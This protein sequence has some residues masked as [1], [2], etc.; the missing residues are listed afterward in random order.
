MH[1]K[2]Y[3]E[4]AAL[5]IQAGKAIM[6]VYND[7]ALFA[8]VETKEDKSPLTWADERS[9]SIIAE[10][11]KHIT[12]DIHLISEEIAV[13]P[14]LIRKN[15][16]S[17][18]LVDPLDGTKEFIKRN[19][20]FTVNIA[21]IENGNPIIGIIYLPALELLYEG[22]VGKGAFKT[23]N[24]N[25]VQIHTRNADSN[26]VATGSASHAKPEEEELLRQFDV[27]EKISIGSSIKFCQIAEGAADIY[28]RHGPT[29]EWDTAAGHAIALAAGGQVIYKTNNES[30]YNKPDLHNSPFICCGQSQLDRTQLTGW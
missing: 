19:G 10:G 13:L 18:W 8:H 5:A 12:P 27:V 23:E 2:I 3:S 20:Q 30:P 6:E 29:M 26:L 1:Q 28:Y 24:G 4:V 7:E 21:L 25:R 9:N 17:Y 11:L 22:Y 14:Y 15:W 16:N